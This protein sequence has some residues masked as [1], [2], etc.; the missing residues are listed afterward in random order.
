[1]STLINNSCP[2]M[3]AESGRKAKPVIFAPAL[4]AIQTMRES[5]IFLECMNRDEPHRVDDRSL[6]E[7]ALRRGSI[8]NVDRL[9][10]P[11]DDDP[12]ALVDGI[13]AILQGP[14][15]LENIRPFKQRMFGKN[16]DGGANI[17][18]VR[19]A[20]D[21]PSDVIIDSTQLGRVR[22]IEEILL[23]I[24]RADRLPSDHLV[25]AIAAMDRWKENPA[26]SDLKFEARLLEVLLPA[27]TALFIYY[28]IA[29]QMKNY[30]GRG[31][32]FLAVG[33][34]RLEQDWLRGNAAW[35]IALIINGFLL[36]L[37][38]VSC[39]TLLKFFLKYRRR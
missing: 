38:V 25:D 20:E 17:L 22:L 4:R 29:R 35:P 34:I 12:I 5:F 36:M 11:G 9:P 18:A 21:S 7:A 39:T 33:L 27:V 14:Q 13:A 10:F 30:L 32:I 15:R 26:I 16:T 2:V 8:A 6:L 31:M 23:Y 19:C 1:M 37:I 3:Q 24:R 28:S